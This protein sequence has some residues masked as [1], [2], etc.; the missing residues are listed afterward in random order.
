M[1]SWRATLATLRPSDSCCDPLVSALSA[2]DAKEREPLQ[3]SHTVFIV[4]RRIAR[5]HR[6]HTAVGAAAAK[7]QSAAS[8]MLLARQFPSLVRRRLQRWVTKRLSVLPISFGA[9][10]HSL[11]LVVPAIGALWS[12][13]HV[14][15]DDCQRQWKLRVYMCRQ[16]RIN[17]TADS[18]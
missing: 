10:L 9:S 14:R 16:C 3:S 7:L 6:Q 2:L 11:D 15:Y 8:S 12:R 17:T 1:A 18:I 13:L 5:E 4:R